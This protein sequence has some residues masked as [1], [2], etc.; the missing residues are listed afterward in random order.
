MKEVKYRDFVREFA[1]WIKEREPLKIIGVGG[2]MGY[3]VPDSHSKGMSALLMASQAQSMAQRAVETEK[4]ALPVPSEESKTCD[5]CE[6][7]PAA[8]RG[9][10][11][12][13]GEQIEVEICQAC[14]RKYN[15][16]GF[17]RI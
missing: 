3:W 12:H 9:L 11:F 1:K 15:P 8:W 17:K 7:S 2:A 10:V 5:K 13:E 4:T 16:Q 6:K 14:Y